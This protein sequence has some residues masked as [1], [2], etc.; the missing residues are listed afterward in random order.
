[1]M[2]HILVERHVRYQGVRAKTVNLQNIVDL[3]IQSRDPLI[4]L[5]RFSFCLRR[6]N[7]AYPAHK[8]SIGVGSSYQIS[9]S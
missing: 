9:T 3:A 5:A 7:G 1:M 6:T 8:G 2:Q 4:N